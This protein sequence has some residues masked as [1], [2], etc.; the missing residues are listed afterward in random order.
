V[1]TDIVTLLMDLGHSDT[2]RQLGAEGDWGCA[3]AWASAAAERGETDEALAM[4]APFA[5]T[6]WWPAVVA[7]DRVIA[8][9]QEPVPEAIVPAPD[10]DRIPEA[11]DVH[12][13]DEVVATL[14]A[15]GR[16]A[17]AVEIL[18][19]A[20]VREGGLPYLALPVLIAMTAEH[21]LHD[22]VLAIIDD[23]ADRNEDGVTVALR[24]RRAAVLALRGDTDQAVAELSAADD[25]PLWLT[26]LRMARILVGVGLLEE[27]ASR[28]A[29][30]DDPRFM[31]ERASVLVRLGRVDEAIEVARGRP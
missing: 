24:E 23:V 30:S 19:A 5:E 18:H 14:I 13:T 16:V 29:G 25:E 4:L 17:E 3:S 10:V 27:A 21:A 20:A 9:A 31:I 12:E 8:D 22:R 28:L 11:H 7:R 1:A 26:E 2:V 6:G 15:Q